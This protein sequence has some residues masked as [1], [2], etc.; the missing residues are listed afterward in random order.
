MNPF[1][2]TTKLMSI[3]SVT[4]T[5][6]EI[7]EFLSSHLASLKYR[8]ERQNVAGDRFNVMAFAG[9][10]RVLLCAHIDTVPPGPPAIPI[11]GDAGFLYVLGACDEKGITPAL[12][13]AG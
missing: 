13:G 11:R 12:F 9:D 7:G 8:V 1:E 2:L 5:E 4:G 10:A 3:P 6:R